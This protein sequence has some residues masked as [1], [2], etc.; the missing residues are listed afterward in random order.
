[1][2]EIKDTDLKIQ[3]TVVESSKVSRVKKPCLFVIQVRC[4]D[5]WYDCVVEEVLDSTAAA[6]AYLRGGKKITY[7]VLVKPSGISKLSYRIVAVKGTV[8]VETT[9]VVQRKLSVV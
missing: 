4:G 1:M 9:S 6:L 7:P 8:E 3:S 5:A 2:S